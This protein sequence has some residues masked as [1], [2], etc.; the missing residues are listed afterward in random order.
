MSL[1]SDRT[2]RMFSDRWGGLT[3]DRPILIVRSRRPVPSW[4]VESFAGSLDGV[5][6]MRV[7]GL[8]VVNATRECPSAAALERFVAVRR[9]ATARAL[10]CVH[11]GRRVNQ[12]DRIT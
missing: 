9:R 12:M 5:P 4:M 1:V 10:R 6:S 8:V 2:D 3:L 11:K 7:T